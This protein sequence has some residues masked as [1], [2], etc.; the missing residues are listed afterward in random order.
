MIFS[1]L[2][3]GLSAT[4]G[5]AA[6]IGMN[7]PPTVETDFP[8]TPD[9]KG[10]PGINEPSPV[11][12]D[13]QKTLG[14]TLTV[15]EEAAINSQKSLLARQL[16]FLHNR[17]GR[18]GNRLSLKNLLNNVASPSGA[19][20]FLVKRAPKDSVPTKRSKDAMEVDEGAPAVKRRRVSSGPSSFDAAT[21]INSLQGLKQERT[22]EVPEDKTTLQVPAPSSKVDDISD[23]SDED[24]EDFHEHRYG[25]TPDVTPQPESL[26]DEDESEM[27]QK[28]MLSP[29]SLV[30]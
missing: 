29:N 2:S 9:G 20:D 14:R 10:I 5:Y 4:V 24:F 21:L 6:G 16:T 18:I 30:D 12:M 25:R 22:R 26:F 11:D 28:E 3:L 19:R 23:P 17:H 7:L 13:T 8:L 27:Y 15:E 1:K